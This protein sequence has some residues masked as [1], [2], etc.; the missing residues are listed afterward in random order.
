MS[1]A[2]Y[3]SVFI[4]TEKNNKFELYTGVFEDEFSYTQLKDKVADVLGLSN[5]SPEDLEHEIYGKDVIIF[6]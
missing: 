3:N 4:R 1:L 5:I 2:V 6:N